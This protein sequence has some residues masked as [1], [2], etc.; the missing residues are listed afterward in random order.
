M[1]DHRSPH[2]NRAMLATAAVAL[3][4]WCYLLGTLAGAL[5]APRI[6]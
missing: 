1:K 5:G 3:I 4:L 2:Q 6:V